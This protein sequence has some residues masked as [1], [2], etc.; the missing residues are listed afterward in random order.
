MPLMGSSVDQHCWGKNHE[1]KE[2]NYPN[3]NTKSGKK[4]YQNM[5]EPL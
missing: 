3:W 5:Q 1:I 2:G 4:A